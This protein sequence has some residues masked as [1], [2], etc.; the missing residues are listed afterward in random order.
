MKLKISYLVWMLLVLTSIYSFGISISTPENSQLFL[1]TNYEQRDGTSQF[2]SYTLGGSFSAGGFSLGGDIRFAQMFSLDRFSAWVF[3]TFPFPNSRSSL[4]VYAKYFSN[5]KTELSAGL[6]TAMG[7]FSIGYSF[8]DEFFF[9]DGAIALLENLE[10]FSRLKADSEV[11]SADFG[12]LYTF[13]TNSISFTLGLSYESYPERL[14]KAFLTMSYDIG[15]VRY[16]ISP[17]ATEFWEDDTPRII[18]ERKGVFGVDGNSV[19]MLIL[20]D[21]NGKEVEKREVRVLENLFEFKPKRL[22][23]GTY[24]IKIKGNRDFSVS[25][26]PVTIAVKENLKS[27]MKLDLPNE[28]AYGSKYNMKIDFSAEATSRYD[29]SVSLDGKLL[30]SN[31][32]YKPG[33]SIVLPLTINEYETPGIKKLKIIAD[34]RI[35]EERDV[36]VVNFVSAKWLTPV[37]GTVQHAIVANKKLGVKLLQVVDES[38]VPYANKN[39]FFVVNGQEIMSKTNSE[40]IAYLPPYDWIPKKYNITVKP[41]EANTKISFTDM[42]EITFVVERNKVYVNWINQPLSVVT[43][44]DLI[45][46]PLGVKMNIKDGNVE[47]PYTGASVKFVVKTSDEEKELKVFTDN[48]GIAYVPIAWKPKTYLITAVIENDTFNEFIFSERKPNYFAVVNMPREVILELD[49][50]DSSLGFLRSD[51]RTIYLSRERKDYTLSMSVIDDEGKFVSNLFAF[52]RVEKVKDDEGVVRFVDVSRNFGLEDYIQLDGN[53]KDLNIRINPRTDTGEYYLFFDVYKD[54]QK[55]ELLWTDMYRIVVFG[56]TYSEM[57]NL[58]VP[59]EKLANVFYTNVPNILELQFMWSDGEPVRNC[60]VLLEINDVTLE[61]FTDDYGI[62]KVITPSLSVRDF[63]EISYRIFDGD[64]QLA[65]DKV[66][67]TVKNLTRAIDIPED[68]IVYMN[69]SLLK[70]GLKTE[71]SLPQIF[72]IEY[73]G[74]KRKYNINGYQLERIFK[75]LYIPEKTAQKR[76]LRINLWDENKTM[77]QQKYEVYG[78]LKGEKGKEYFLGTFDNGKEILLPIGVYRDGKILYFSEFYILTPNYMPAK[79]TSASA[80]VINLELKPANEYTYSILLKDEDG[81]I[82]ENPARYSL[83]IKQAG[84]DYYVGSIYS[85][86]EAKVSLPKNIEPEKITNFL[87]IY[88]NGKEI[89]PEI[90]VQKMD[91]YKYGIIVD[92]AN[93]EYLNSDFN[94]LLTIQGKPT[95]LDYSISVSA[96]ENFY[97]YPVKSRVIYSKGR[98]KNYNGP[99]YYDLTVYLPN[100]K[101]VFNKSSVNISEYNQNVVHELTDQEAI[102]VVKVDTKNIDY[103]QARLFV[104]VNGQE[105]WKNFANFEPIFVTRRGIN[106]FEFSVE[107]I[108]DT[109]KII[110]Y[111]DSLERILEIKYLPEDYQGEGYFSSDIRYPLEVSVERVYKLLDNSYGIK[112]EPRHKYKYMKVLAPGYLFVLD[113]R[114]GFELANPTTNEYI[115]AY[116]GSIKSIKLDNGIFSLRFYGTD[117]DKVVIGYKPV[118]SA[119]AEKIDILSSSV[120]DYSILL[121]KNFD[122]HTTGTYVIRIEVPKEKVMSGDAQMKIFGYDV[123]QQ[124]IVP[125]NISNVEEKFIEATDVVKVDGN[126]YSVTVTADPKLAEYSVPLIVDGP[127]I[128]YI[129][130]KDLPYPV[131]MVDIPNNLE[132][133]KIAID[134]SYIIPVQG[135]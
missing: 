40:G 79:F 122:W 53:R 16:S 94:L 58:T 114:Y 128:Y 68:A 26:N 6:K 25:Y 99:G 13:K 110:K 21:S 133:F 37:S 14:L 32:N 107:K 41:A 93:Q 78:V 8:G 132:N 3:G 72:E 63:V 108:T 42:S 84:Q 74:Y 111:I 83:Y 47:L 2:L 98:G 66:V 64:V 87:K 43:T 88:R 33:I 44:R 60:Y 49:S 9:V 82:Y 104:K 27:K 10:L 100:L 22:A 11:I 109:V 65:Q 62:I 70:K 115:L 86:V 106:I 102:T 131:K 57:K 123:T 126:V 125:I 48:N 19:V 67:A 51:Q 54:P 12:G 120:Y 80:D 28:L 112:Y 52:I 101:V 81:R 124:Y 5:S 90:E 55:K 92:V 36:A 91:V 46:K 117:E 116:G 18:V 23:P 69:S 118:D 30:Y 121:N 59:G 50:D 103:K 127:A 77:L 75:E 39:I 113:K 38:L 96:I 29:I 7:N 105:V 76:E 24:S 56:D 71:L 89:Q 134:G 85:G 31:P 20:E 45:K 129:E 15:Y 95:K 34:G 135:Y 17:S 1:S 35:L 97:G 61:S 130:Y 119:V 4:F 73:G